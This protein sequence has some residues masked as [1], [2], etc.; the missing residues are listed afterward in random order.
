M[1]AL[2]KRSGVRGLGLAA[3]VLLCGISP[4]IGS[5][6]ASSDPVTIGSPL[7]GGDQVP[8]DQMLAVSINSYTITDPTTQGPI[9]S[10]FMVGDIASFNITVTALH[11]G[12]VQDLQP[13]LYI[14]GGSAWGSPL[15]IMDNTCAIPGD[16]HMTAGQKIK[17]CSIDY[18]LT[19]D[20][21]ALGSPLFNVVVAAVD[22]ATGDV[23]SNRLLDTT[24]IGVQLGAISL[25]KTASQS[26]ITGQGPW[27][28]RYTYTINSTS[29]ATLSNV[30]IKDTMADALISC[31]D[32]SGNFTN[33]CTVNY[34]IDPAQL[35]DGQFTTYARLTATTPDGPITIDAFNT[36]TLAA[37]DMQITSHPT[38]I[39][40]SDSTI[41]FTYVITNQGASPINSVDIPNRTFSFYTYSFDIAPKGGLTCDATTDPADNTVLN[42]N[43]PGAISLPRFGDSVTCHAIYTVQQPVASGLFVLHDA[44]SVA[45]YGDRACAGSACQL[46]AAAVAMFGTSTTTSCWQPLTDPTPTARPTGTA[47]PLPACGNA[48]V[49]L[50]QQAP[51][52]TSNMEAPVLAAGSTVADEPQPAANGPMV[53]TGGSVARSVVPIVAGVILVG[54]IL[55]GIFI[56]R[57]RVRDEDSES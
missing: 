14:F 7:S 34:T 36:I 54:V 10:Q 29:D 5:P 19:A 9:T 1:S 17:N 4:M 21:I 22:Q 25:T 49:Q 41:A 26:V 53:A 44:Q 43:T 3:A 13:N 45:N 27:Q 20:D 15:N 55:A 56:Y 18:Q 51:L 33:P 57:R 38:T 40:D 28:I 23:Y 39:T 2:N 42:Q 8:I 52:D 30:A 12:D 48:P 32:A 47:I 35:I 50:I 37:M 31:V 11:G 24:P 46:T 6:L 16:F